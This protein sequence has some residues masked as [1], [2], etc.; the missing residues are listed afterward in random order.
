ML[1]RSMTIVIMVIAETEEELAKR[2][3]KVET[4]ISS[5]QMK[6]RCLASLV[7][8]AF[9]CVVPFFSSDKKIKNIAKRNVP[10]S[11][12][13]GGLPFASSRI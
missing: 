1:F 7:K 9:K 11:T 12:F 10:L 8:N 5:M 2:C 13:I 4:R 3:K 6:I